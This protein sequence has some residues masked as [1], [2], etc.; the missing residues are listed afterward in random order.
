MKKKKG[1]HAR[2]PVKTK[3][4]IAKVQWQLKASDRSEEP[5]KPEERETPESYDVVIEDDTI[6]DASAAESI[7]HGV[8]R[9]P[10]SQPV[11]E[12]RRTAV[13]A[14]DLKL[15][16]VIAAKSLFNSKF[17][18]NQEAR[19]LAALHHSQNRQFKR[20]LEECLDKLHMHIHPQI[21]HLVCAWHQGMLAKVHTDSTELQRKQLDKQF[22]Y[23]VRELS[24]KLDERISKLRTKCIQELILAYG[25]IDS[26][27]EEPETIE[28]GLFSP[29]F[30]PR[31]SVV[32]QVDDSY[33]G[34]EGESES[35]EEMSD[36]PNRKYS[37][38]PTI[39]GRLAPAEKP[40]PFGEG[41]FAKHL[42]QK[43]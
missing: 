31:P 35:D 9:L 21:I 41:M 1:A 7:S 3:A 26:D 2:P 42:R 30:G 10:R 32:F 20:D 17:T 40:K 6:L 11:P 43:Y 39:P 37:E 33:R 22:Q 18:G 15:D 34:Y 29:S 23:W 8:A 4:R 13:E 14:R 38:L 19:I 24:E 28:V 12:S 36:L 16:L 27:D 5:P 25:D